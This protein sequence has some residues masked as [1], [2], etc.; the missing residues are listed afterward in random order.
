MGQIPPF[1]R[2]RIRIALPVA[3][4]AIRRLDQQAM[5]DQPG[6]SGRQHRTGDAQILADVVIAHHAE[7]GLAQDKHGPAVADFLGCLRQ[8]AVAH[9]DRGTSAHRICFT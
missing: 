9:R 4:F 3:V 1:L 7:K 6:Q 8:G 2:Q 5:V